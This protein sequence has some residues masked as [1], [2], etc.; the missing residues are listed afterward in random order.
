MSREEE[1]DH[2]A[3]VSR[4]VFRLHT[5]E[6][7]LNRHREL[8]PLRYLQLESLLHNDPRL[9]ILLSH[10]AADENHRHSPLHHLKNHS[11]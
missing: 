1:E 5:L 11:T 4:L 8:A 9:K 10:E 3:E 2:M 7:R 6:A